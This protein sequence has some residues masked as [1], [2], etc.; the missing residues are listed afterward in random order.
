MS[1][2]LEVAPL[3]VIRTGPLSRYRIQERHGAVF[4]RYVQAT[5]DLKFK[6]YDNIEQQMASEI[7]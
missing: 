3:F 5:V 1:L 2:V 6:A 7:F 4:F